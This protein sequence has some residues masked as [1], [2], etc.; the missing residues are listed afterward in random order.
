MNTKTDRNAGKPQ[1]KEQ[2]DRRF[3]IRLRY[4][5]DHELI[6]TLEQASNASAFIRD[7]LREHLAQEQPLTAD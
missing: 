2:P 3:T 7:A 5:C 4:H 6:E 1:L